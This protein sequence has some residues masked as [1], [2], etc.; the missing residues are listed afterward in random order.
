MMMQDEIH[1]P[2]HLT[3][4]VFLVRAAA[5]LHHQLKTIVLPSDN[6]NLHWGLPEAN[7]ANAFLRKAQLQSAN[8]ERADLRNADLVGANL[9]EAYLSRANFEGADLEGA[10]LYGA[11]LRYANLTGANMKNCAVAYADL[12]YAN[13]KGAN[14]EGCELG[15]TLFH[16]HEIG[17]AINVDFE[18]PAQL[19][20]DVLR[21]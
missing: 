20:E 18:P 8:L 21:Q 9:W 1:D 14:L 11:D 4:M 16:G 3:Y 12:R 2:A 17:Q 13:L 7:L 6:L 15:L 19:L 5:E 10:C